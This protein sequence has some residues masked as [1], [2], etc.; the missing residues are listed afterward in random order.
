LRGV[1]GNQIVACTATA[2]A[3]T[4]RAI[5]RCLRLH[6]TV[7]I[8]M[9][10]V[11]ANVHIAIAAKGRGRRAHERL[12]RVLRTSSAEQAIV[13]CCERKE[14]E[15]VAASLRKNSLNA[16]AYHAG[17]EDREGVEARASAGVKFMTSECMEAEE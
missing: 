7:H 9:P 13:F 2:T 15:C 10:V 4:A 14:C 8:R 6:G 11:K 1:W 5:E 12:V 17:L 16:E 3:R